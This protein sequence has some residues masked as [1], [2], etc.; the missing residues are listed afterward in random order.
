MNID[1][2]H[3]QNLPSI[4]VVTHLGGSIL[5]RCLEAL[6]RQTVPPIKVVVAVSSHKDIAVSPPIGLPVQTI[7]IG[8][9]V[10]FAAAANRGLHAVADGDVILLNDD[11]APTSDFVEQLTRAAAQGPGIYQPRIL[12]ADGTDRI[13]NTGHRLFFDGFNMARGRGQTADQSFPHEV[14]SFSGAAVLL[15]REVLSQVGMFDEDLEAFGEDTDL[16]FRAHRLGFPIRYIPEAV[17]HHTLGA[18][19]GRSNPKKVFLVERNRLR[20]AARSLPWVTLVSMPSWTTARFAL[21]GLAA[22][23]GHGPGAGTGFKGVAAAFAGSCAGLLALPDAI[24]KRHRDRPKWASTDRQMLA[25]FC[26]Q[27]VRP[28]DLWSNQQEPE[29]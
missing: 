3:P 17:I 12:L 22:S 10:G 13:D 18:S 21:L 7:H 6:H 11:T 5:K 1:S 24:K 23:T 9:N 29:S 2:P 28:S 16:S 19:Y 4:V 14:G 27:H 15:T 26:R 8:R 25:L 20:A